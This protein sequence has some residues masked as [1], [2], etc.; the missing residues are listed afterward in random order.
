V[1]AQ[2]PTFLSLYLEP[3][4]ADVGG[5]KVMSHS[6]PSDPTQSIVSGALGV[7]EHLLAT[8]I[9][10]PEGLGQPVLPAGVIRGHIHAFKTTPGTRDVAL[11][12]CFAIRTSLG[13]ETQIAECVENALVVGTS[14]PYELQRA[15]DETVINTDDRMVIRWYAVVSGS[16]GDPV[17]TLEYQGTTD[18][19]VEIPSTPGYA[20]SLIAANVFQEDN[21]F[22]KSVVVN[23]SLGDNDF[24]VYGTGAPPML[25]GDA[26]SNN[27]GIGTA[28]PSALLDVNGNS[29]LNGTVEVNGQIIAESSSSVPVIARRSGLTSGSGVATAIQA[30]AKYTTTPSA[31]DGPT[32]SLVADDGSQQTVAAIWGKKVD[33]SNGRLELRDETTSTLVLS[34]HSEGGTFYTDQPRWKDFSAVGNAQGEISN[35]TV[36]LTWEYN[37]NIGATHLLTVTDARCDHPYSGQVAGA[38]CR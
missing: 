35:P 30:I 19:R 8:W 15:I 17:V 34:A 2:N 12:L 24:T 29:E 1:L 33:A 31:G 14:L 23:N 25:F 32:I 6:I 16:G 37:A 9:G 21:T 18:A 38:E 28:F 22:E 26:S 4:A 10:P 3:D 11:K 20:A 5:Y 13:V 36:G 27:V 7:G